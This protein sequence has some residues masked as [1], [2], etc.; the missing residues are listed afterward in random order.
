MQTAIDG[1]GSATLI[2]SGGLGSSALIVTGL[3]MLASDKTYELWYIGFDGPRAAGTFSARSDGTA[4][5]VLDGDMKNGDIIGV[6]VEPS[7]GSP[8]PTTAP[9]VVLKS[10]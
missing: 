9:I 1:G 4:W 8:A 10:A 3:P 6:T 2:W 5:R 7:G